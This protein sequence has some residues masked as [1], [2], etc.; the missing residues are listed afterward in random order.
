G[1]PIQQL[2]LAAIMASLCALTLFLHVDTWFMIGVVMAPTFI[3]L[4]LGMT[5]LVINITAMTYTQKLQQ[6]LPYAQFNR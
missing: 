1:R 3:L 2:R 4:G 5:C 6:L